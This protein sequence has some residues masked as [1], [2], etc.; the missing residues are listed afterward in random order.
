MDKRSHITTIFCYFTEGWNA[1]MVTIFPGDW[2]DGLEQM[3]EVK[4]IMWDLWAFCS[5]WE[6][7]VPADQ[8]NQMDLVLRWSGFSTEEKHRAGGTDE[9]RSSWLVTF[10]WRSKVDSSTCRCSNSSVMNPNAKTHWSMFCWC[11]FFVCVCPTSHFRIISER[12][13]SCWTASSQ[14]DWTKK[15]NITWSVCDTD[16]TEHRKIN[17]CTSATLPPAEF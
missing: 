6:A 14:K 5:P 4:G 17:V 2:T 8:Y 13:Y 10:A 15:C 12:C 1:A 16:L 11:C 3:I 7:E 9:K